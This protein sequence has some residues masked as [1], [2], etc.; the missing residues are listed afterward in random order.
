M[1][2]ESYGNRGKR[3]EKELI[4]IESKKLIK[5]AIDWFGTIQQIIITNDEQNENA[6]AL[7]KK[8]K[9]TF[10]VLETTRKEIVGP[11][12]ADVKIVN[13]E[14]KLITSKLENF[15][16]VSKKGTAQ[17]LQKQEQLRIAEQQ[18]LEAQAEEKRRKEQEAARREAD[19]AAEYEKQGRQEMADKA[20]AR[21]ESAIAAATQT[22][23]PV[24]EKKKVKGVSSKMVWKITVEDKT[25]ALEFI[26]KN[27]Q[28]LNYVELDIT[29]LE[30]LANGTSC[31]MKIE[32]G[33]KYYQESVV[34]VRA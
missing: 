16:T 10:N 26:L 25:K 1:D 23:A 32:E 27:P 20:R 14:F 5:G 7:C 8:V 34:S 28:Y 4:P 22:V 15:E 24:I 11:W 31:A 12:N 17:Y 13:A 9:T 18:K 30:K 6:M 19:K 21:E 33:L 3:E 29:G 2:H